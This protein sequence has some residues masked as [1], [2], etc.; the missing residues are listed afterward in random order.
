MQHTLNL[1][2][3]AALVYLHS[4]GVASVCYL[5]SFTLSVNNYTKTEVPGLPAGG[6]NSVQKTL[7]LFRDATAGK[8]NTR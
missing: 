7:S 3:P 5:S 4:L 2:P 1:P 6:L 8:V